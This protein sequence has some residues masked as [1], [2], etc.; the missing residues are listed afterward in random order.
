MLRLG[1]ALA[2]AGVGALAG[3]VLYYFLRLIYTAR[4]VPLVIKAA[5]PVALLGVL[6]VL[7]ALVRERLRSRRK[8]HFEGVEP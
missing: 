8:E 2:I 1:A 4:D 5:V 7:A 3:Y 6:L